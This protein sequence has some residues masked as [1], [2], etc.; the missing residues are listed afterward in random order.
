MQLT[1]YVH[2]LGQ[3][4]RER[5][6]CRVRKLAIDAHFSCPNRDGSIGRGG[7]SFCN[8]ASF[9]V[10]AHSESIAQQLQARKAE[11]K[12]QDIVYMAYFQAYSNTYGE[13]QQ[14][15][16][17]YQQ[18][19]ADPQVM[20]L[21]IGTRPDCVSDEILQLLADYQAQGKEVWLELGLQSAQDR[22]LKRIN[23]GHDFACYQNTVERANAYGIAICTHLIIG[24]PGE[25]MCDY[26]NTLRRVLA[27]GVQGIKLHP[28]MVVEG[29]LMAKAWR[30]GKVS[31]QSLDDYVKVAGQL[32]Q[33]T[34]QKVIFHRVCATARPP[35]LLSPDWCAQQWPPLTE[36]T[37]YLATYGGQGSQ[38]QGQLVH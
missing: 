27:Q 36:I 32:I 9:A 26:Q 7:C 30:A 25:Q 18:A 19:L 38:L 11:M 10:P 2:T 21:C 35:T 22:T 4:W 28:L 37:R 33:M 31:M 34:P 1:D 12:H 14:L 15:Q 6:G 3:Y 20:G 17:L 23:R 29:S 16:I 13:Y 8:V 24:L 5:Y